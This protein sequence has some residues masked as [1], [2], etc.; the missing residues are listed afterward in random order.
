M[1][2][3]AKFQLPNWEIQRNVGKMRKR[4]LLTINYYT[5][6][7]LPIWDYLFGETKMGLPYISKSAA[8]VI[9]KEL[10]NYCLYFRSFIPLDS[11][12]WIENEV[13]KLS[14]YCFICFNC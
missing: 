14:V 11:S 2:N 5:R 4:Q 8:L 12:H 6:I 7:I 13:K 10:A 1:R 9:K 3:I